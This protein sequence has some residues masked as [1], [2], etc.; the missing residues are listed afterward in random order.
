[1]AKLEN[2]QA[3]SRLRYFLYSNK[4]INFF[5]RSKYNVTK[6]VTV[7]IQITVILKYSVSNMLPKKCLVG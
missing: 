3:L 1:M 5:S 6:S 7:I 2:Y 4:F